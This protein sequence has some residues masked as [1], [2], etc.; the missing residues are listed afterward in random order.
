V[1]LRRP[2]A[3]DPVAADAAI[4]AGTDGTS[5]RLLKTTDG[6]NWNTAS[7]TL[8][9][10]DSIATTAIAPSSGFQTYYVAG[11]SNN[12]WR[13][14]DG[15]TTWTQS[16]TGLSS[17]YFWTYSIHVDATTPARALASTSRGLY[18]TTNTGAHWDS[19]VGTGTTRLP[20]DIV[21]GAVF[22]P[23][24]ANTVYAVTDIGAFRGTITPAVGTAPPD[25]VWTPFDEGLPD[26]LAIS[27]V[28]VNRT[29][30]RLKISSMGYG[31]FE[32]DVRP[33]ITCPAAR[34]VVRDNVID[35]GETPSPS[36]VPDPEHPIPDPA[37]RWFFKPDDTTAGRLYWWNSTDVRIDVPSAAPVKNQIASADHV[38]VETCPI[39]VADCPAG[40][41]RDADPQRGQAARV[42]AQVNNMGLQPATDVRVTALFADASTGLPSLPVDFWTT[43]LPAGSTGC[44]ALTAGSGWQFADPANPCR[45]IPTVNPEYPE[46]VRFD[47]NVPANQAG[48]S[49]MLIVAESAADPI[50]ASVRATNERRISELVPNNRQIS[51][52]NL[53]VIDAASTSGGG[54]SNAIEG[55]NASNPDREL[56]YVDLIVSRVDLPKDAIVGFLLP[57]RQGVESVG[58]R[59]GTLTLSPSERRL[60]AEL[61]LSPKAFYRVNDS[62][63]ARIRLPVA[64]GATWRLGL[65]YRVRKLPAGASARFSV[66]AMQGDRTLGGNT[67]IIRSPQRRR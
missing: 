7:A 58:A 61:K 55:M 53:H 1:N 39:H 32:R 21:M 25:A 37:K 11:T 65:V 48:H 15:G 50:H 40:T 5:F 43:T 59:A 34:L 67:Y 2:V 49:C 44:G 31:T 17:S 19:I 45:L 22:D 8:T 46:T 35:R 47:W 63:E 20:T 66:I 56:K 14:T 33:G 62:R 3:T 9:P 16:S 27:D 60:A 54:T 4:A 10:P 28:W 57:T 41:I 29:T 24:D 42:Y 6:L 30:K 23:S 12:I 52:R 18:L 51:L 38:E 26:A 13:T 36:G 64:P